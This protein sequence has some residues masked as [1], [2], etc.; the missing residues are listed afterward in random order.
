MR[1][2]R[3]VEGLR[4]SFEFRSGE[5]LRSQDDRLCFVLT[6]EIPSSFSA[7]IEILLSKIRAGDRVRRWCLTARSG[8]VVVVEAFAGSDTRIALPVWWGSLSLESHPADFSCLRLCV[9]V[10]ER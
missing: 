5:G 7:M 10:G 8:E 1:G 3:S 6:R 2:E 9:V 4:T